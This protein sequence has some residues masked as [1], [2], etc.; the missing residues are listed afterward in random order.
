LQKAARQQ[1]QGTGWAAP[2]WITERDPISDTVA[3]QAFHMLAIARAPAVLERPAA[4]VEAQAAAQPLPA[5]EALRPSP[6]QGH[7]PPAAPGAGRRAPQPPSGA[8]GREPPEAARGAARQAQPPLEGER[9]PLA[10]ADEGRRESRLAVSRRH[11]ASALERWRALA[12]AV[13]AR[14]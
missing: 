12:P 8:R 4:P 9:E 11:S 13:S 3:G 7:E 10:A 2:V 1:T 6:A 5:D 14:C